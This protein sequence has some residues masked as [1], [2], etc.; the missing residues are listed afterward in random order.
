M[1]D[2]HRIRVYASLPLPEENAA[3]V[4]AILKVQV[5]CEQ[6]CDLRGRSVQVVA[7]DDVV[8]TGELVV[9]DGASCETGEISVRLPTDVGEHA[10]SIVFPGEQTDE[11]LH[12]DS[13]LPL[14]FRTIPHACSLA[15]WDVPSRVARGAGFEVKVG[16]RCSVGC[17]LAGAT[18]HVRDESGASIGEGMLG[19]VPWTGTSAL[20]WTPIALSAPGQEG[21]QTRTAVFE[22]A[23]T[24][25][26]HEP[27]TST[28]SFRTDRPREHRGTVT[29]VEQCTQTP[30]T[31]VEV[32]CGPYMAS[33]DARGVASLML[34]SGTFEI[35]I[36]KDGF[37]AQPLR[38][39]IDRDV[40][41]DIEAARV[42][43]RAEM[44]DRAFK[45]YP[46]G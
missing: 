39:V 9:V 45:D 38:V 42:P 19:D 37:Q 17:R 22:G 3:G 29:V 33:T 1:P 2:L 32:R 21:V 24:E 16:V 11:H 30:V 13:A 26:P 44:A 46:W 41:V 12:E 31:R 14:R 23:G 15:V 8:A 43:T 6:G 34:P 40:S 36:R 25:L 28:F 18:V 5:S 35:T 7:T 10:W 27:A 4:S 20:R